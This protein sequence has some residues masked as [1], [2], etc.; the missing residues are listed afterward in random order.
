M[1]KSE[2]KNLI[3]DTFFPKFCFVCKKEGEYLCYDCLS[4]LEI[5]ESFFCLCEKPKRMPRPEKCKN[6]SKKS[7]NGLYFAISYKKGLIKE[8]IHKFKYEPYAKEISKTLANI[9]CFYF[10]KNE[11]SF[12]KDYFVIVPVPLTLKKL[13]RRGFNQSEEIAKELSVLMQIPLVSNSLLKTKE[14]KPQMEISGEARRENIKGAFAVKNKEKISGK[15][16]LLLDDVYTTG[17]TMEECASILKDTGAK[18]VW[19]LAVARE[20]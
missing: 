20:E 11:K 5:L 16:I 2:A 13:K 8:L 18:E 3:F 1:W 9:I 15:K 12:D 19:G 17:S 10:L 14:T 7:L 4:S 6:C